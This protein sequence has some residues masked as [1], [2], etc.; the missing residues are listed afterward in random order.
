[1]NLDQR[2]TKDE[3]YFALAEAWSRRATCPRASVGCVIVDNNGHVLTSGYN[4][5]PRGLPHCSEVGC[6]MSGNNCV[7]TVHAELNAIIQAARTGVSLVG[8][9]LYVTHRP[10]VRCTQAIIQAGIVSV[11]YK[12]SYG[13]DHAIADDVA[14]MFQQ[15]GVEVERYT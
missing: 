12:T 5:S 8:G 7:R 15:S 10:C 9:H 3:T 6:L 1:M 14:L 11:K 13:G 2:P 4:G